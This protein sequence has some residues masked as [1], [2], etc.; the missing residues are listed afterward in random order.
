MLFPT[1]NR[2]Y[3]NTQIIPLLSLLTAILCCIIFIAA[4]ASSAI[5]MDTLT[6]TE[7]GGIAGQA[8]IT[9]AA[10]GTMEGEFTFSALKILDPDETGWLI[11]DGTGSPDTATIVN[12][13]QPGEKLVL[14]CATTTSAVTTTDYV[15]IPANTTYLTGSMP[16]VYPEID[17]PQNMTVGL[18]NS[19]GTVQKTFGVL[20]FTSPSAQAVAIEQGYLWA[21]TP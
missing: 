21:N 9:I 14:D 3:I 20:R 16:G 6:Q 12:T 19:S 15:R 17:L 10:G 18:G 11:M 13:I 4:A 1:N 5:A 8:G 7:M 2:I